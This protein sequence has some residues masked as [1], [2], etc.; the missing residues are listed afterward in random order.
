MGVAKSNVGTRLLYE[1][2][3]LMKLS[4]VAPRN[5]SAHHT[6]KELLE[7]RVN[8][9]I[10]P[11]CTSSPRESS[12]KRKFCQA[13]RTHC[14]FRFLLLLWLSPE[15]VT[16]CIQGRFQIMVK[17]RKLAGG[18]LY[19]LTPENSHQRKRVLIT[20]RMYG[21]IR[22]SGKYTEARS[23]W[24]STYQYSRDK[25]WLGPTDRTIRGVGISIISW[26]TGHTVDGDV[27]RNNCRPS[28]EYGWRQP[29]AGS[30]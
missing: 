26:N 8:V 1:R 25:G 18:L 12:G 23:T 13:L 10:S 11:Y 30:T 9:V 19:H 4:L 2:L 21:C 27:C 24:T 3:E 28:N 29:T 14:F 15:W 17:P 16:P 7:M 22:L 20:W 5:M 6:K